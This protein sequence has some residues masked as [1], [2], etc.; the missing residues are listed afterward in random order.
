MDANSFTELAQRV[1]AGEAT[2]A[3]RQALELEL[4]AHP[5]RRSEFAEMKVIHDVLRT[6]APLAAAAQATGPE[7]PAWRV[8]EL[9]TAVRQHFGATASRPAASSPRTFLRWLL[10]GGATTVFAAV[11]IIFTFANRTIEVG[12]YQS[13][14]VRGDGSPL[15]PQDIPAA[16]LVTFDQDAPFDQWQGQPLG[17]NEHAKIWVDNERDVLHV[18]VRQAH[19][20]IHMQDLPLAPTTEGQREQ[21]RQ[22]VESLQ[23]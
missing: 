21:I 9:R 18:V 3:E 5:E 2:A 11:I 1:L 13:G 4:S 17:W 22:T 15:T 10:A 20:V 6:A 16:R 23:K 7:L 14:Q 19:G 8:N 12:L